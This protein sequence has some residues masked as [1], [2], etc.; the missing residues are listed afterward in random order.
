MSLGA[1]LVAYELKTAGYDIGVAHIDC[2]GYR[3]A[4]PE[5]RPEVVGFWLSGEC[6]AP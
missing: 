6:Y 5:A 2:Q 4:S 1:L 3:I